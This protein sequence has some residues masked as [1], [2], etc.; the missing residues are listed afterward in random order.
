MSGVAWL[1]LLA[2]AALFAL[3]GCAALPGG[4]E[5]RESHSLT[6]TRATTLGKVAAASAPADAADRSGFRL[7]PDADDALEA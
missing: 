3:A 6:E 4:I 5:R 2:A 7:L 1:R